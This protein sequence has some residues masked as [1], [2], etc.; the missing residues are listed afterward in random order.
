[1]KILATAK[2]LAALGMLAT[3][4]AVTVVCNFEPLSGE[5]V[6]RSP[7]SGGVSSSG[8]PLEPGLDVVSR[9][10]K[11][12][13]DHEGAAWRRQSRGEGQLGSTK[14]VLDRNLQQGAGARSHKAAGNQQSGTAK[15]KE[16]VKGSASGT[17][18]TAK[19][20]AKPVLSQKLRTRFE[21]S[22]VRIPP[23]VP[24][25][26][27]VWASGNGDVIFARVASTM[28]GKTG[29]KLQYKWI[30]YHA[31]VYFAT[32]EEA[33]ILQVPELRALL[34]D[35]SRNMWI[36]LDTDEARFVWQEKPADI[37]DRLPS[38]L[39]KGAFLTPT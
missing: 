11:D 23:E 18:S 10:S 19:P 22:S 20:A 8:R 13:W 1:M 4:H 15:D 28:R 25:E 21:R 9:L 29:S 30:E 6:L 35:P 3:V 7:S 16:S 12:D 24:E 14:G 34:W 2:M 37:H 31:G 36:T 26:S 27:D 39:L 33:K 32:F 38:S 17:K 5:F